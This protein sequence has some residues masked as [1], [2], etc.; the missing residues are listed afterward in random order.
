MYRV[1]VVDDDPNVLTYVQSALRDEDFEVD[2][3]TNAEDVFELL[4]ESMPAVML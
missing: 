2:T 3:T 1:L 4:S